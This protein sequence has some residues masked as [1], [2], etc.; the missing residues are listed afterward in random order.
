M[1]E[2]LRNELKKRKYR[3]TAQREMILKIF[4]E[5]RGRHLGVE[6]VYR[7]LLN[8][9]VRISKAT[10][11]RSVELLVEL[12]FLRKLNFG[13]GLYRYELADRSNRESH[14]HVICQKCGRIVE[15]NSEQ[16]NKIIS[17]ISKKTGYVIKW[18]DLKFYGI[19]P[20]CQAKEKEEEKRSK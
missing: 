2:E 13:E 14:Q 11:Y 9:N 16:V 15:I 7:E 3:I 20:E 19:C 10:V 1:Y 8:R 4:L 17:D 18:H 5:S 6:E 12:G